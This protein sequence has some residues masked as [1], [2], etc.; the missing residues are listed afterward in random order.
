MTKGRMTERPTCE[1]T[2]K[3]SMPLLP[4]E[5]ATAIEGTMLIRRVMILLFQGAIVQL[6]KPSETT[7]PARVAV[8]E[9]N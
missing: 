3:V 6:R 4:D 5:T 7:C 8:M 2:N 1:A 9:A